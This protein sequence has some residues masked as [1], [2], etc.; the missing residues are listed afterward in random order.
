MFQDQL[1]NLGIYG[2][3]VVTRMLLCL[4][5]TPLVTGNVVF[6]HKLAVLLEGGIRASLAD[7]EI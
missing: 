6:Y 2:I 3:L 5:L 1:V 4:L 7:H